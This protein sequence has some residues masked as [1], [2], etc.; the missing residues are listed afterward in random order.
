MADAMKTVGQTMKQEPADELVPVERH[1]TGRVAM[2]IIA[3]AEDH[4]AIVGVVS[5]ELSVRPTL[6]IRPGML[7][8]VLVTR[9]LVLDGGQ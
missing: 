6:T 9:D 8:R 1:V 2:T 3:P 4:A 5:R 7:V